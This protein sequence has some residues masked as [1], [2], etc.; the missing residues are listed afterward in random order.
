MSLE[1]FKTD[2]WIFVN[3]Q[4][5]LDCQPSLRVSDSVVQYTCLLIRKSLSSYLEIEFATCCNTW[6]WGVVSSI[7][8]GDLMSPANE[9]VKVSRF[10]WSRSCFKYDDNDLVS[11]SR[12]FWKGYLIS[13]TTFARPYRIRILF[14]MRYAF[15]NH[16]RRAC[17]NN[18]SEYEDAKGFWSL[19]LPRWCRQTSPMQIAYLKHPY[20]A[21]KANL[22]DDSSITLHLMIL[23]SEMTNQRSFLDNTM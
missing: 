7:L 13:Y 2:L 17:R 22:D 10:P 3:L 9:Y 8:V 23:K 19:Q 20:P 4:Q 6:S 12:A 21:C 16:F 5:E 18:Q 15:R 1:F 11:W 14:D